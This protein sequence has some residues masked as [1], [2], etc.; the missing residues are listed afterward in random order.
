M[1]AETLHPR[2]LP[3][4]PDILRW[5]REWRGRSIADAAQKAGVSEDKVTAWELGEATPTVRQARML[6]ACYDRPFLEFFLSKRPNVAAPA[7]VPDFRLHREAPDPTGDR[8]L[9]AVQSWAEE[10]RHSALDLYLLNY[11]EAPALPEG[12]EATINISPEWA[13]KIARGLTRFSVEEQIGLKSAER[14][15]VSK[16][17]RRSIEELGIL[18]LKNSDLAKYQVR[19]MTIFADPLP[20]IVYST[21]APTAQAFTMAHELGHVMLKQSAISG[22]P[23]AHDGAGDAETFERWCDE[24]AGAFLV[25]ADALSLIWAKPNTPVASLGDDALRQLANTFSISRHA[26]LIRL[27]YLGYVE[28]SYYWQVK[29]P[30]FLKEEA[31][32][33]GGGRPLY[34]GSRYR[35]ANGDLFTGLVLDAWGNGRITN[36]NAAELMGI[37]S[38]QHLYDIRDNFSQ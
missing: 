9:M 36:H 10:I 27:V 14:G 5:A 31:E 3:Y 37:K 13:A 20:V 30:D 23:S 35:N 25:P 12:F 15:Q 4:N 2:G 28:P 19:G 33:R 11:D 24:F 18:V 22:P 21:E 38:L 6:A 7:L 32:F 26:M 16:L 29:R 34:Y 17:F 8:E 1:N